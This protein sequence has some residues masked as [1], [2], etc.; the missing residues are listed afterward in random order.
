MNTYALITG[1]SSGI[2]LEFARIFAQDGIHLILVARSIE[3]LESIKSELQKHHKIDIHVIGLDLSKTE[4]IHTLAQYT[5]DKKLEVEYL[6]NNAGF[7]DY[8]EF[9]KTDLERNTDMIELNIT[10]LTSLSRIY[11]EKMVK[12]GS[13][14]ILN[15]AS[16]AAFQ[17]GP[18]MAVYFATKSF[19]LNFSL[20]LSEELK[21]SGVT[22][23]TLC[24]GPTE[25]NFQNQA[26]AKGINIFK[27][28]IPTSHEVATY[29]YK[30]MLKGNK[31]AIHGI[32]NS[33]KAFSVKFLPYS[34]QLALLK[35]MNS[36]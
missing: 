23:T 25:S 6:I 19:V 12:N 24:P 20:A 5:Q 35:K 36:K 13:G 32:M 18:N 17:P 4:S 33:I 29:G 7:G 8:G 21:G 1:A 2:G 30:Q 34:I 14:K 15:V 11:A 31:I 3:K 16:T 10:A 28:K 27:G 22:I 9:I 26:N